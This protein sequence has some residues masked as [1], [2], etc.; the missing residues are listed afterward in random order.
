MLNATII[1]KMAVTKAHQSERLPS[2]TDT[3]Y[4]YSYVLCANWVSLAQEL[5][6][7]C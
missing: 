4:C 5:C 6:A 7:L 3:A 2:L 1:S